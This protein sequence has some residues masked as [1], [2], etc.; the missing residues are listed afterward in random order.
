MTYQTVMK[1]ADKTLLND[2]FRIVT[3]K[4]IL[5]ILIRISKVCF[6]LQLDS[7]AEVES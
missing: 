5:S 6:F 2:L 7:P 4:S 3:L 1:T